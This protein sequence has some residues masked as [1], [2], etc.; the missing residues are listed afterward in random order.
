MANSNANATVISNQYKDSNQYKLIEMI[1]QKYGKEGEILQ[2]IQEGRDLDLIHT[3]K[4]KQ[5]KDQ[6]DQKWGSNRWSAFQGECRRR[7]LAN[8][9]P[10][11]K[12]DRIKEIWNSEEYKQFHEEWDRVAKELNS[13]KSFKDIEMPAIP[14]LDDDYQAPPKRY[15][16]LKAPR[17]LPPVEEAQERSK[18][19]PVPMPPLIAGTN[20]PKT[21]F[22]E[23]RLE[24]LEDEK[25]LKK[26][27]EDMAS[28]CDALN[29][30]RV[31]DEVPE[32]ADVTVS[33]V[34][35]H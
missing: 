9:K 8:S 18:L 22:L 5:E 1:L 7:A 4:D 34:E 3:S 17:K 20:N 19:P 35:Q 21:S 25:A 11:M 14:D 31:E 2:V 28:F 26:A 23:N 15:E 24:Q 32:V 12:R 10:K 6:K 13:G 16:V 27:E 29:T 33:V 30:T